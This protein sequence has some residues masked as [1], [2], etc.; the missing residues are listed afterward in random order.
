MHNTKSNFIKLNK[1]LIR[2]VIFIS[3]VSIMNILLFKNMIV[4]KALSTEDDKKLIVM[5]NTKIPFLITPSKGVITSKFG[6]RKGGTHHG[7]DIASKAG[8]PIKASYGGIV[9]K[10][11]YHSIYGK[12]IIINHGN[13]VETLYAHCS[14][15]FVKNGQKVYSSQHIANV[16]NT[17]RSSGPHIHFELRVN[18]KA[19]NPV[20]YIK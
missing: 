15:T 9:S 18:G 5:N 7:I 3:L 16:G 4:V 2:V 19:I 17:G 6:A 11:D 12:R 20:N 13:G 8:T 14:D 1:Y 10:V